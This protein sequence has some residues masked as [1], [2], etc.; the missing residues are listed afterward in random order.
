MNMD[1]TAT[2]SHAMQSDDTDKSSMPCDQ[3]EKD[4]VEV[5]A[6]INSQTEVIAPAAAKIVTL[7][8]WELA[9]SPNALTYQTKELS[10]NGPPL[11]IDTLIGTVVLRT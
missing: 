4:R 3:C 9:G 11:P 5:I 10:A 6:S 2:V 1:N 7:P 8:F